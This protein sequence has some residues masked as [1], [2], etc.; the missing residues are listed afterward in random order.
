MV[1][2]LEGAVQRGTAR[3]LASL[4]HPLA[5]KTGTTNDFKDAWFVGF[6]PDLLVAAYIGIDHPRYMGNHQSG[7][8]VG[9]VPVFEF[10]KRALVGKA[11]VP[12]RMPPG[13]KLMRVSAATG[14]PASDDGGPVILEAF[15]PKAKDTPSRVSGETNDSSSDQDA[16]EDAPPSDEDDRPSTDSDPLDNLVDTHTPKESVSGTGGLY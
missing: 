1:S 2:F 9:L 14:R 13:V 3:Q 8:R 15:N 4:G 5:G 16:L 11:P 7:A 12:F 10:F 6:S